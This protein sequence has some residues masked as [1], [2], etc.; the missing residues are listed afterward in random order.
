MTGTTARSAGIALLTLV[1]GAFWAGGAARAGEGDVRTVVQR[2]HNATVVSLAFS[3][4]G[5]QLASLSEDGILKLW[6]TNPPCLLDTSSIGRLLPYFTAPNDKVPGHSIPRARLVFRADGMLAV[7]AEDR[8]V[9]LSPNGLALIETRAGRYGLSADGRVE[10]LL[11]PLPGKTKE[12]GASFRVVVREAATG[13]ERVAFDLDFFPQGSVISDNGSFLVVFGTKGED[14]IIERYDLTKEASL[15]RRVVSGAAKPGSGYVYPLALSPDGAVLAAAVIDAAQLASPPRDRPAFDNDLA[16]FSLP[17]FRELARTR[18]FLEFT[19]GDSSQFSPG[20]ELLFCNAKTRD[21]LSPYFVSLPDLKPALPKALVDQASEMSALA[22]SPD[23]RFW[24]VG[25]GGD[26]GSSGHYLGFS[27]ELYDPRTHALAATASEDGYVVDLAAGWDAGLLALLRETARNGRFSGIEAYS[28]A[29]QEISVLSTRDGSLRWHSPAASRIGGR[30][31]AFS[32]N[33]RVLSA[34]GPA[35]ILFFDAATGRELGRAVPGDGEFTGQGALNRAGTL[36]AVGV[37]GG[38]LLG[39]TYALRLVG[40][41]DGKTRAEIGLGETRPL[42]LAFS[43]N[44]RLLAQLCHNEIILR[45]LPSGRVR[46]RLAAP[47]GYAA[48][49]LFGFSQDGGE[50][51]AGITRYDTASG[52]NLG[53]LPDVGGLTGSDPRFQASSG[54]AVL[55]PD[56]RRGFGFDAA[57]DL[58]AIV[59]LRSKET[60]ALLYPFS[61]AV[62]WLTPDGFF[63]GFGEYQDKVRFVSANRCTLD[64]RLWRERSRPDVVAQRMQ[65]ARTMGA[66]DG[67]E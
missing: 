14:Q 46:A 1:C 21:N 61:D 58:P 54:L 41:P 64:E 49:Y 44:G 47:D 35:G 19:P 42:R 31:L 52:K 7:V 20:G 45:S 13:R 12:E 27:V 65:V 34:N 24:A 36:A 62:V 9:V 25:R 6:Q 32:A 18:L 4:D 39:T 56:G 48:G 29:F 3:K 60:V 15:L 8:Q 11:P 23:G 51:L 26:P 57:H 28:G 16:V 40:V 22:F 55:L 33:G 37:S 43:P 10:M 5:R 17:D 2:G 30:F 66:G 67:K 59:D 50:F 63:S 53:M 38:P